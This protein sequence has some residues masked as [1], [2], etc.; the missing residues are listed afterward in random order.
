LRIAVPVP[1]MSMNMSV[2]TT[3]RPPPVVTPSGVVNLSEVEGCL[4]DGFFYADG[5]QVLDFIHST[6]SMGGLMICGNHLLI[7]PLG[8]SSV[9]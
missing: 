7:R 4:I 8:H 1:I 6:C 9:D 5:A 2:A 3:T